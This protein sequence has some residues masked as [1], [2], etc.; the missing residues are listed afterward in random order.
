M[1]ME[2]PQAVMAG[3]AKEYIAGSDG[4][5]GQFP[6]EI[7]TA[8]GQ[9]GLLDTGQV[10]GFGQERCRVLTRTAK[11]LAENGGDLGLTLSWMIHHLTAGLVDGYRRKALAAEFATGAATLSF[12]V[13]EPKGGGHPKHMTCRADRD[14]ED[15]VISGEKAYLTNGPVARSFVVVAVTGESAGKKEFS[16]FLVNRETPGVTVLPTMA[17]PFFKS[18]PHGGICLNGCRVDSGALVGSEGRAFPDL[19]LA[20]RQMED[21]LMTG[22]V[23][24]AMAKLLAGAA[25]ALPQDRRKDPECLKTLGALAV[26]P[27]AA[28][29]LSEHLACLVDQKAPGHEAIHLFFRDMASRFVRDLAAFSDREKLCLPGP[30]P[31]LLRDL[32]ASAKLGATVSQIRTQKLAKGLF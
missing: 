17:I 16:A 18:A 19:V 8:M 27:P 25:T 1:P 28:A 7:W 11:A 13:S 12:A 20:F 5:G 4:P 14:G 21:A 23:T 26:V 31:D 9:K 29:V 6:K 32:E 24:G 22:A 10:A 30:C 2:K 3:F 15:W